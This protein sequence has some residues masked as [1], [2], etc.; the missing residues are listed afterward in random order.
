MDHLSV[1]LCWITQH[2][3]KTKNKRKCIENKIQSK[4][5]RQNTHITYSRSSSSFFISCFT[6]WSLL[7]ILC[8]FGHLVSNIFVNSIRSEFRSDISN[9]FTKSISVLL[10]TR[11]E[12]RRHKCIEYFQ[13]QSIVVQHGQLSELRSIE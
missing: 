12:N 11:S 6:C 5:K 1:F 8:C 9:D 2:D 10:F 3:R 13:C 7:D 4:S